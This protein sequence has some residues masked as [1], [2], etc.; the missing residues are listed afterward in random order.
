MVTQLLSGGEVSAKFN[1]NASA[2]GN[3]IFV[4]NSDTNGGGINA[5]FNSNVNIHENTMQF[6]CN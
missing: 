6:H 3:T 1:S 5:Q 2:S 4:S